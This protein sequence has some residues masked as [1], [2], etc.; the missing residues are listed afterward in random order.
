MSQLMRCSTTKSQ[1]TQCVSKTTAVA[2]DHEDLFAPCYDRKFSD[3]TID[4]VQEYLG[5]DKLSAFNDK[6]RPFGEDGVF[7]V[8][9]PEEL[10]ELLD[11][12]YSVDNRLPESSEAIPYLH[13]LGSAQQRSYFH[14]AFDPD[15]DMSLLQKDAVYLQAKFPLDVRVPDMFQLMTVNSL[16]GER[17]KLVNSIHVDDLLTLKQGEFVQDGAL[18][19]YRV[20]EPFDH[21]FSTPE[22]SEAFSRN[23]K[24]QT[25]LMAP[26]S[27][28]LVYNNHMNLFANAEAAKTIRHLMLPLRFVYVV[29]FEPSRWS[30]MGSYLDKRNQYRIC[31]M[32]FPFELGKLMPLEQNLMWLLNGLRELFPR[33]YLG[34][35]YNFHQIQLLKQRLL[36][37]DFK[38]YV[39]C[40]ENAELPTLGQL[41]GLLDA[42][43]LSE[44]VCIEF[45]DTVFRRQRSLLYQETLSY[46]NVL[47]LINTVV[48][49][50]RRNVLIYL[51]DGFTGVTLLSSSLG[52]LWGADHAETVVCNLM[53]RLLKLYY[54]RA[55]FGFLK[56]LEVY[57]Q[58]F[59]RQPLAR[60]L[61]ME[62]PFQAIKDAHVPYAKQL[63]WFG[64]RDINFPS[65]VYSN[66]FLGS[67]AHA[68]SL[69]VLGCMRIST[70]VSIDERPEWASG[71]TFAHEGGD[72]EPVFTFNGGSAMVYEVPV[73][74]SG[75]ELRS[76]VYIC[77]VRDDGRDSMAPLL[78]L[79]PE[80]IQRKFLVDPKS[81][82]RALVHCKMGVSRL[83]TLAIAATMKY[84]GMDVV[85]LYMYVRVR[86]YNVVVQPNVRIFYELF[87]YDELLRRERGE[88]TKHCWWVVCSEI[89]RLNVAYVK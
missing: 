48:N 22:C 36:Q 66:L 63:D 69:A 9:S 62:L 52:L 17:P 45:P 89:H 16:D 27:H 3:S 30:A 5:S 65:H 55:D 82:Q 56:Q 12:F 7:L 50:M 20:F 78:L 10:A 80:H 41:N 72:V 25:R 76:W 21:I 18:F 47:N 4:S 87:L 70:V 1:S 60:H 39:Y 79:C 31:D 26:L 11:I 49:K 85:E 2:C 14:E 43:N 37:Y 57:L 40:H 29:D 32:T 83:A 84:Y 81:R 75:T 35:V 86:R 13:G 74:V 88:R 67:A 54:Q 38:L 24:L 33:A 6:L 77:N 61:L 71:I 23:F 28:F 44:P 53:R 73:V 19:D 58:W 68:S 8:A 15:T 64:G 46:I 51:Y 34:N 42:L 59:K